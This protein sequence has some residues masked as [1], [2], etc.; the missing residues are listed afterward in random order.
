MAINGGWTPCQA[1][2]RLTKNADLSLYRLKFDE[3]SNQLHLDSSAGENLAIQL[4]D[5]ISVQAASITLSRWFPSSIPGKPTV[6][7]ANAGYWDHVDAEIAIINTQTIDLLSTAAGITIDPLRFRGNLYVNGLLPQAEFSWVGQ[8]IRIGEAEF[9]ITR[10]IDRCSATSL[11]P[12]TGKVDVNMPALLARRLGHIFC[13]VYARV[14]KAGQIQFDDRVEIL[15][16]AQQIGAQY[17]QPE[18]APPAASW[19]RFA[20]VVARQREDQ[21]VDSFWLE[22]PLLLQR[23]PIQAGQHIRVHLLVDGQP[24]WRAYTV[25]AIRGN[26]LRISVKKAQQS[27]GGSAWLHSNAQLDCQLLIS[28]PYGNFIAP[29]NCTNPV[30]LISAGIG[31]TPILAMLNDLILQDTPPPI[32]VLHACQSINDLALW[33]EVQLKISEEKKSLLNRYLFLTHASDDQCVALNAQRGVMRFDCIRGIDIPTASFYMCG[34]GGFMQ[35]VETSLNTLG[36]SKNQIYREI[37][38]SPTANTN[39]Q[40]PPPA[41][42]P[43]QITFLRKNL[44]VAWQA[45][46]GS[47]LDLAESNGVKL[48][49]NCRSGACGT[50]SQAV[51]A[52]SIF[53]TLDPAM[54]LAEHICLICCAV[55]VSNLALDI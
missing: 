19:P 39:A 13:G 14:V 37:F 10:P 26:W 53:H 47:L 20:R 1:F 41:N 50:C 23:A 2:I 5:P 55:P 7:R 30:V 25:S 9:T 3:T 24:I 40:K 31:I 27:Q 33:D 42:G 51:V 12:K 36:V 17:Q 48:N 44:T 22:D 35:Y 52:G 34:P 11:D 4:N 6:A 21:H 29:Q 38:S 54:P 18:T 43:F 49:A 15:G 32:Y 45:S 8:R 46:S 28:G 16:P